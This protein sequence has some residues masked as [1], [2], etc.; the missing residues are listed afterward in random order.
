MTEVRVLP[1]HVAP[2]PG[3][4]LDSWLEAL[5]HRFDT[6]LAD[7]LIA[8]GLAD[9]DDNQVHASA[10]WTI[11]LHDDER[12]PLTQ[13]TV[14]T[15]E[16]VDAMTLTRY[17]GTAL[18]I[19]PATGSVTRQQLWGRARGSR[20]C[21]DCLAENDGRWLLSWRLGWSFACPRHRRLLADD[22]PE[23]GRVPR[24]RPHPVHV[25]P[26]PGYCAGPRPGGSGLATQ[27]CGAELSRAPT[28]ALPADHPALTAQRQLLNV[29]ES[30]TAAFGVYRHQPQPAS[31]AL[32]DIRALANRTLTYATTRELASI[33]PADILAADSEFA[34]S[35]TETGPT[36]PQGRP[37]F[38]APSRA[39]TTAVAVT[40]AVSALGEDNV[41]RAGA[42]LRWLIDSGR[43]RGAAV[44]ATT[45]HT[46]G[47]GTTPVLA[48]VQ[49]A[50]LDPF[51]KPSDRLRYRSSTCVP[52]PPGDTLTAARRARRTPTLLWPEWFARLA[53]PR[54]HTPHHR[55][56]LSGALQLV[57]TELRLSE[58]GRLL[59]SPVS[60]H[61]LSRIL[62]LF[63]ADSRWRGIYTALVR[64]AEYLDTCEVPIDYARRRV[65]DYEPLL[66]DED[67]SQLC[68]KTG[69]V[70]GVRKAAVVRAV[71]FER[72]SGLPASG[73]AFAIDD[74]DFRA[75]VAAFPTDLTPELAAELNTVASRFLRDHGIEEP[76]HWH[77]PL[78][79]LTGLDLPGAD[80]SH[81]D[82]ALLHRLIRDENQGLR[83]S[84]ERLGTTIDAVRLVLETEPAPRAQASV[85]P[86]DAARAT[87][88]KDDLANLYHRQQL[89]L[90]EIAGKVGVSRQTITRLAREYDVD[91]RT[92]NLL[93]RVVVDRDWLYE[94][95]VVHRR[96]LPDLA[97]ECG[98]ST[99]NMARWAKTHEIPL[100]DRGGASHHATL[101]A[102]DR[103]RTAPKILRPALTSAGA[104]NRLHRFVAAAEFPTIGAAACALG[105]HQSTLNSQIH[106]LERDLGGKLL[107][108]AE[109]GRPMALTALGAKV[110]Q[111]VRQASGA[112]AATTGIREDAP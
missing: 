90:R 58:A 50:A 28:L 95:Y 76:V 9:R 110:A 71:L 7:L 38:M 79:L 25:V 78:S 65:L 53:L 103:S 47:R 96:T 97:R 101:C 108:R 74:S 59:D 66:A 48:A 88:N 64:L 32:S 109:R 2:H 107:E 87:I 22:C 102:P 27:R 34:R 91:V 6:H 111:E 29:I 37:G 60:G 99:A 57:G 39:V 31:A 43:R 61:G 44:N 16:T 69:T 26:Q 30:G 51:L 10:R 17:D 12:S 85:R 33:V 100:R 40:A 42:A 41:S 77:P 24:Y 14:T 5:A 84:A 105:S 73:A 89:S 3:E 1:I 19:D 104:W 68:R 72:I 20:F 35:P 98:M 106:R 49:L 83:K 92:A 46:W 56:A 8:L 70:P 93:P 36:D 81:I 54:G 15:P 45:I 94:Q 62:Q 112:R 75:R 55:P 86:L 23:C 82:I 4:A 21:P 13:A 52:R 18:R 67:W 80:P 11:R 63:A